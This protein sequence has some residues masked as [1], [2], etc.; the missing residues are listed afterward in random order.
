VVVDELGAV[1]VVAPA[2]GAAVAGVVQHKLGFGTCKEHISI[3][4]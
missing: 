3:P 1:V 2:G 4:K